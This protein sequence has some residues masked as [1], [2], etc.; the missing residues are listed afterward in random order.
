M[1]VPGCHISCLTAIAASSQEG[2]GSGKT[3][4]THL[5]TLESNIIY[6][7]VV[8]LCKLGPGLIGFSFSYHQI[9][10][11]NFILMFGLLKD[12]LTPLTN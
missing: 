11:N 4:I 9:R 12:S 6:S 10:Y 1:V 8:V 3:S 5:Y 2:D 7:R